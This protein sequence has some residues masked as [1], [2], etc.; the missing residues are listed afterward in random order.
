M[1]HALKKKVFQMKV[2]W[3]EWGNLMVVIICLYRLNIGQKRPTMWFQHDGCSTHYSKTALEALNL[4][5]KVR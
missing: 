2:L 5:Y 1:V 4:Y 3:Y